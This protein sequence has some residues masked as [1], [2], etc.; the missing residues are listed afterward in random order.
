MPAGDTLAFFVK[1]ESNAEASLYRHE[2]AGGTPATYLYF[3]A[4][5]PDAPTPLSLQDSWEKYPG[6]PIGQKNGGTYVFTKALPGSGFLGRLIAYIQTFNRQFNF[7][8]RYFFWIAAPNSAALDAQW[9]AF[10][11]QGEP[12]NVT[13]SLVKAA[14]LSLRNLYLVMEAQVRLTPNF[15]KAYFE[16]SKNILALIWL[17]NREIA[18]VTIGEFGSSATLL[19]D[20]LAGGFRYNLTMVANN[21]PNPDDFTRLMVGL[22]YFYTRDSRTVSQLYPIFGGPLDQKPLAFLAGF[23]PLHALAHDR[24]YFT[25]ST[26]EGSTPSPLEVRYR[27]DFGQKLSLQPA[28]G[29]SKLVLQPDRVTVQDPHKPQIEAYHVAPS[30]PFE[31]NV[32]N[33]SPAEVQ[34]LPQLICGLSGLET[35]SFSKPQ[36]SGAPAVQPGDIVTFHPDQPAQASQFPYQDVSLDSSSG[37]PINCKAPRPA[38]TRDLTTSWLT[39]TKPPGTGRDPVY[40]AQPDGSSLYAIGKGTGQFN[41]AYLGY[42]Q[43]VTALLKS[44]EWKDSFPL[45]PYALTKVDPNGFDVFSPE[46]VRN[47]EFQILAP[48][49][50]AV[51][52]K[53]P[54]NPAEIQLTTTARGDA[55]V[56]PGTTLQGLLAD[57]NSDG[58]WARL[59]LASLKEPEAYA[60]QFRNL[61][62]TLQAAFQ[63]NQMFLVVTQPDPCWKL[64]QSPA[65]FTCDQQTTFDN[66]VKLESW[67]FQINT[68]FGNVLGDY[69]NVLIFKFCDGKLSDR[70]KNPRKW[71]NPC[72]FNSQEPGNLDAVS[73]WL[74]DYIRDARMN[75][76]QGSDAAYFQ[77]F[78]DIVDSPGWQGILALRVTVNLTE[79]PRELQGLLA[80]IDLNNFSA[81]HLG[82]ELAYIKDQEGV[83]QPEGNSS[84]FG[85]IYY[86]DPAFREQLAAEGSP[87]MPVLASSDADYDFKVLTLKVLFANSEIKDF[88]SKT[89]ITLNKLFDDLTSHVTTGEG[90]AISNSIVLDGSYENHDGQGVYVFNTTTVNKFWLDSNLWNYVE[91]VKAQ[92]S[93]LNNQTS[94]ANDVQARF[95]FWGFLNFQEQKG[96]DAI[97]FGSETGQ[98]ETDLHQ[99]LSFSNLFLEM[100]FNVETPS[101]VTYGLTTDQITF[102]PAQSTARRDSLYQHFPINIIG[103]L[104]GTAEKLPAQQGYLKVTT[105][106][107]RSTPLAVAWYGFAFDLNMGTPGALAASVGFSSQLFIGWSPGSSGEAYRTFIGIKLPGAGGGEAKTFSLQGVLRLT[108]QAIQLFKTVGPDGGPAYM[109]RLTNILLSILGISFP[110]GTSTLFFLFG[111]PRAGSAR[112]SL[113]WYAAVNREPKPPLAIEAPRLPPPTVSAG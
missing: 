88:A 94:A 106:Q 53:L 23:D 72:A 18:P 102:S 77:H 39:I 15:D 100:A 92:F 79:F 80:G 36:L 78:I 95:T 86:I 83:L 31:V 59:L 10:V 70:V 29:I 97:S 22:K 60:L 21:G 48:Q 91:F 46:D 76:A 73:Q 54:Q 62:P 35:V 37:D 104:R 4:F 44:A 99:G 1:V 47:F 14:A 63:T 66:F 43:P 50:R 65:G 2:P 108:I 105:N 96:F 20:D 55:D 33:P 26:P 113:G 67:P 75:A 32:I 40:Y 27:T 109:L 34:N 71:T 8:Y 30:G 74:Q 81:H 107:L 49:R 103:M 12:G 112:N 57:V 64:S 82:I 52:Q 5:D 93:T 42:F 45:A 51:I 11:T 84:L 98:A 85:L 111:D 28:S 90:P 110:P 16:F 24:T 9:C 13:G 7:A 38:I 25:F 56:T 87:M 61:N 68:G 101:Q 41:P 19:L 58:S 69:R 6:N 17:E 89:Q 3:I